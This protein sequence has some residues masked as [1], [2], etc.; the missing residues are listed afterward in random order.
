LGFLLLFD[1]ADGSCVVGPCAEGFEVVDGV[2]GGVLTGGFFGGEEVFEGAEGV[3]AAF[4]GDEA[5]EAL[6]GLVVCVCWL[7]GAGCALEFYWIG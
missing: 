2:A 5:G 1:A 6:A 3:V 7:R 4:N